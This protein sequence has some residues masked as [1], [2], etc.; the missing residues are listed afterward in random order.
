VSGP[1]VADDC[2]DLGACLPRVR[3]RR[4]GAVGQAS[5]P[6]LAIAGDPAVHRLAGHPEPLGDLRDRDAVKD[7][8]NGP[9]RA[10]AAE[11]LRNWAENFPEPVTP[12][13]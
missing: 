12:K 5:Q 1:Q 11:V 13:Y 8:K 3:L 2:L 9:L 4:V 7:L 10:Q 6:A